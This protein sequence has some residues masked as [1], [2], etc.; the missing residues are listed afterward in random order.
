MSAEVWLSF[1]AA[2]LVLC[3]TPGPTVLIVV[4][5][6]LQHGKRSVLPLLAGVLAGDVVAMSLS[7]LGVGVILQTSAEAFTVFKFACAGYL[8]YLGIKSWRSKPSADMLNTKNDSRPSG[9][10]FRQTFLVTA[11]N[12]KGIIF[13]LAFFPLFINP[14]MAALPQMLTLGATFLLASA[15]GVT[16]YAFSAGFLRTSL[17]SEKTQR[18]VNRVSGGLL[19]SAGVATAAMRLSD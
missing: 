13:F 8:I 2:A 14:E 9:V 1:I 6:A 19:V 7:L 15:A 12:P 18:A 10:I 3:L 5:K 16:F 17:R 11:L 4:G